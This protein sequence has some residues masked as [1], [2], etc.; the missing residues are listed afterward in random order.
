MENL[1]DVYTRTKNLHHAYV[2]EGESGE[3]HKALVVFLN[4]NVQYKTQSNP[5][6]VHISYES[7]G[8][9]DGRLLKDMQS[10]KSFEENGRKI[11][12]ISLNFITH[13]AQNSLLKIL[14]EP[15]KNTHFFIIVPSV[16][17]LLP[18]VLS[19]V[20]VISHLSKNN[21]S[22]SKNDTQ[23]TLVTKFISASK[24]SRLSMFEK[25]IEEKDKIGAINFLNNLEFVLYTK[26]NKNLDK[27]KIFALKQVAQIREY[28]YD[29]APSVKM[30]MEHIALI[31]PIC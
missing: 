23:K 17:I 6:F 15:T 12:V 26:W 5:D 24:A 11:F 20:M 16:D 25:I 3:V 19:R 29:R 13:E 4:S 21:D 10:R 22:F 27:E 14:E 8:I 18:T 28:L 1:I 7:F 30:L 31:T 9:D 2:L